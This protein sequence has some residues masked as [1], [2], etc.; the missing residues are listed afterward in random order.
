MTHG[1]R[2][3][4]GL[5]LTAAR[6][7]VYP[8]SWTKSDHEEDEQQNALRAFGS[9]VRSVERAVA[10]IARGRSVYVTMLVEVIDAMRQAQ[11]NGTFKWQMALP[12]HFAVLIV[13]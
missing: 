13:D 1:R 8:A 4:T 12:L 9:P 7:E 2:K 10:A 11:V 3:K 5:D 6:L